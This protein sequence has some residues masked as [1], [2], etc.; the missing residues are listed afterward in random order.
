MIEYLPPKVTFKVDTSSDQ[1][2]HHYW[3]PGAEFYKE[4]SEN[5]AINVFMYLT[6]CSKLSYFFSL[7]DSSADHLFVGQDY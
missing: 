1:V 7:K 5:S 3:P 2:F 6:Y 4:I